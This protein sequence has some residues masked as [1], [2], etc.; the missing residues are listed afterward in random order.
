MI[1]ETPLDQL[2]DRIAELYFHLID[3]HLDPGED[4]LRSFYTTGNQALSACMC[5]A[6]GRFADGTVMLRDVFSNGPL[7]TGKWIFTGR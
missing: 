3:R 5:E 4:F 1:L 6:D 2:P 7:M